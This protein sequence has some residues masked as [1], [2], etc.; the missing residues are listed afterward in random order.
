M[1]MPPQLA[2]AKRAKRGRST[3]PTVELLRNINI[4]E[5]R[6]L[7]PRYPNEIVEPDIGF[8]LKYPL[9][10][11]LRLSCSAI[12]IT[13]RISQRVQLFKLKWCK[14]YFGKSRVVIECSCGRGAQRLF[15]KHGN[16]ACRHCH[17]AVFASQ[18][19]DSEG[20]KRLKASYLRLQLNGLP[21]IYEPLPLK[22]K[23]LRWPTYRQQR[24]K[25]IELEAKAK[26]RHFS[27]PLA[28][29]IFAH[30]LG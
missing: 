3:R 24:Q 4:S 2:R 16:W 15:H 1:S 19:D 26:A 11:R 5:L 23:W 7:V 10:E 8:G 9:I 6:H 18:K 25:I 22:P 12:E 21:N 30:R 27:K 13:C 29:Q 20:R 28:I 14:T 17:R